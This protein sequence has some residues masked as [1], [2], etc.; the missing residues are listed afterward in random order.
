MSCLTLIIGNREAEDE[1]RRG[2]RSRGLNLYETV[3]LNFLTRHQ[4]LV[5]SEDSR[6]K[7]LECVKQIEGCRLESFQILPQALDAILTFDKGLILR[8]F[9]VLSEDEDNEDSHHWMLYMPANK[10]LV[11]GPGN[12]WVIETEEP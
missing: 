5:G 10:V 11:T 6:D 12:R 3:G 8:L 1:Q 2:P 7:I 4:F 9:S